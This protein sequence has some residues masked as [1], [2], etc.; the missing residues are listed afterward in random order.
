MNVFYLILIAGLLATAVLASDCPED[1]CKNNK[2]CVRNVG[3]TECVHPAKKDKACSKKPG[4]KGVYES[5]PP[6]AD[7]L[8]CDTSLTVPVC[9]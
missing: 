7:G 1:P 2:V 6:C 9:K 5:Q 4:R 8:K 3:S